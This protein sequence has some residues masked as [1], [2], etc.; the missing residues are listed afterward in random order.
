M[1]LDWD[2]PPYPPPSP[3]NGKPLQVQ[4]DL[5][6]LHQAREYQQ[7]AL[8]LALCPDPTFRDPKRAVE[9]GTKA[10]ELAP[11]DGDCWFTLGAAQYRASNWKAA[12]ESLQKAMPLRNGGDCGDWFFLAMVHWQL[13]D[14]AKA[15]LWY[16]K[17]DLW[18]ANHHHPAW[19]PLRAEAAELLGI[20]G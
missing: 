19:P 10:V 14:K 12:L 15:C 8:L 3:D 18:M 4:I 9:L 13:G 6:A 17:A 2:M 11:Q 7:R 5:G 20:K 1:E 16:D